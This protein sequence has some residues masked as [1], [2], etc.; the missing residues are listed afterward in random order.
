MKSLASTPMAKKYYAACGQIIREARLEAGIS[1]SHLARCIY[2]SR[3]HYAN[4]EAGRSPIRLMELAL[5]LRELPSLDAQ[6]FVSMAP[7]IPELL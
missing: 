5:I 7:R 2:M 6:T 4:I 1:Q 3:P